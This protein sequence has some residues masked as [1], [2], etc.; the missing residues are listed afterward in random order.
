MT[1]IAV[2]QG[3]VAMIGIGLGKANYFVLKRD[4]LFI[5][6]QEALEDW[7]TNSAPDSC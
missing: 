4:C 5:E 1:L 2:S 6:T 7:L 3:C